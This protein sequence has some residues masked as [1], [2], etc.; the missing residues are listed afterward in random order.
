MMLL[1]Y[2]WT[3]GVCGLKSLPR[4]RADQEGILFWFVLFREGP[5]G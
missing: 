3:F 4:H 5:A 2:V 1:C